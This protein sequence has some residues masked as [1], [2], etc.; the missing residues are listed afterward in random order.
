MVFDS[1]PWSLIS[2]SL[3][4]VFAAFAVDGSPFPARRVGTRGWR[5]PPRRAMTL[6]RGASL[7]AVVAA[8]LAASCRTESAASP[9]PSPEAAGREDRLF[10]PDRDH[11]LAELEKS[12]AD[13]RD[14]CNQQVPLAL[15][16][17]RI[18]FEEVRE[19]LG[20][21]DNKVMELQAQA[22]ALAEGA[23]A[24]T[25][26]RRRLQGLLRG[27]VGELLAELRTFDE[28]RVRCA[29][30]PACLDLKAKQQTAVSGFLAQVRQ[31]LA[32]L[33]EL[34]GGPPPQNHFD[35]AAP[36]GA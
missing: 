10:E 24:E 36:G 5:W 20:N 28:E 22:A 21:L 30:G 34:A 17:N 32:Q 14:L 18:D 11:I 33:E 3:P 7:V 19:R 1:G 12:Y 2:W 8:L 26:E 16:S 27:E 15:R 6:G 31:R 9:T 25:D 35:S 4:E 13:L 29:S 23:K